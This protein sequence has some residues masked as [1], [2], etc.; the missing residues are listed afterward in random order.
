MKSEN[1]K[2]VVKNYHKDGT[3]VDDMSSIIIPYNEQF[4]P[5][6]SLVENVA[7]RSKHQSAEEV[8]G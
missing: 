2:P 6:Y 5:L 3:P 1:Y 8:A 4:F 7:E